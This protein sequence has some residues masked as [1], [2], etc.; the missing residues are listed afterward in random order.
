[1]LNKARVDFGILGNEE[2]CCGESARKVGE[3]ELFQNLA[4]ANI[5]SFFSNGV[6]KNIVSSPHCYH[7]FKKEYP[8]LGGDFEVIHITQLLA[9][10]IEAGRLKPVKSLGKKVVYHD[11]CYLGRHNGIYEEPR[12][13]LESIPG[14]ELVEF[15]DSREDSL[16]CGGGGGRIWMETKKG[17]RF[18]D[19]RVEQAIEVGAQVMAISCPYCLLNFDD[20]LLTTSKE[21]LLEIKDISELVKE[22]I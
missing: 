22:V 1:V 3:E 16:C 9:E 17:E 4:R 12:R 19:I 2:N 18:S 11:P 13:V 7:T 6:T 14:L 10:L 5:Q 20:S 8:G 21:G 15:P